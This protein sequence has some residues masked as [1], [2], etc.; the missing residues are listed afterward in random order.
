MKEHDVVNR[1]INDFTI[2]SDSAFVGNNER[3]FDRVAF[4]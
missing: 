2:L 1:N 3:F 4:V